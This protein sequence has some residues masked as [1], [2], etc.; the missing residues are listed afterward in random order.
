[1]KIKK[2]LINFAIAVIAIVTIAAAAGCADGKT[3]VKATLLAS[4]E[5]LI[6]IRAD[7][8]GGSFE[9]ALNSFKDDG[10]LTYL[11]TESEYGSFISAINGYTPDGSKNEFCAVYTS[12]TTYNGVTYSSTEYGSYE[13]NGK[14]LGSAS[15]GVSGLP[16]VAG[17]LYV[18]TISTY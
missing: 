1:M 17:E 10:K 2:L 6:V 4:E 12:L 8:N 11:S 7:E 9:D 15:Y 18:I 3:E 13:Y 14:T 16:L 5:K